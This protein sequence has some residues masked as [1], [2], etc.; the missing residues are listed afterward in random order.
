MNSRNIENKSEG[1]GAFRFL[2]I[3][4][5][6]SGHV[7]P[8]LGT[9]RSLIDAGHHVGYVLDPRW[10]DAVEETGAEF[11]PYDRYPNNPNAFQRTLVAGRR[12]FSTA[13][14]IGGSYDAVLYEALFSYGKSLA[15]QLGVPGIRLS[16]TFAYTQAILDRLAQ[17]GGAHVTRLVHDGLVMRLV[18]KPAHNRGL[19]QKNTIAAEIVSNP[20]DLTYV[21]TTRSFQ[22]DS[23][24]FPEDR[25]RFIGPSLSGHTRQA[26]KSIDFDTVRRPLIYI[27]LGTLLNKS[28]KFY[29]ACIEAFGGDKMS[30][31]MSVGERIDVSRLGQLPENIKVFRS[32]DQ[33]SVLRQADL[34]VTHGGMNSVN[35][36]LYYRVPMIV[37]P[38]GNDQ[39]TVGARVEELGLGKVIPRDKISPA[40]LHLQSLEVM[41]SSA[42]R[43]NLARMSSDIAT[44]G[45]NDRAVREI[46][47]LVGRKLAGKNNP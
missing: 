18:S 23:D 46:T 35:E 39:P 40:D 12:A 3:S 42:I 37:V 15:D 5:P 30:V 33:L 24:D 41:K 38:M 44:A 1:K 10:R 6:Y 43:D 9:V 28:M 20:P 29:R 16:S 8:T 36:S 4:L 34:F 13:Q 45:G 14:R 25:F 22:I 26:E 27:S 19:I 47:E 2:M 21:Y 31:I 32:I 17:T 7:N 11:I